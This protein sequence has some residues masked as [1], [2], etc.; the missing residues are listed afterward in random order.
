MNDMKIVKS[1]KDAGK[2]FGTLGE[3]L[4]GTLLTMQAKKQIELVESFDAASFF[5]SLF[6]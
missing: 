1:L 5:I 2:L 3:S 6:I 4:L